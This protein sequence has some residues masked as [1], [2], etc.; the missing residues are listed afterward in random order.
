LQGKV[1]FNGGRE[2]QKEEEE[3]LIKNK[4]NNKNIHKK[5]KISI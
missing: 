1:S 4:N 3:G 2:N 5:I